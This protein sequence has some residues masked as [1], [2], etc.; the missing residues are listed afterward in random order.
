M[1]VGV[2]WLMMMDNAWICCMSMYLDVIVDRVDVG[3]LG[4][5][6]MFNDVWYGRMIM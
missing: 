2:P 3:V 6:M 5:M 4:F 1:I